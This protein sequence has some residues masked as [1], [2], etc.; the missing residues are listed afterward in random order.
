VD[1]ERV[2]TVEAAVSR[3]LA[4]T[5]DDELIHAETVLARLVEELE[6]AAPR[7]RS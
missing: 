7:R 4:R 5:P 2:G 3:T 1:R 6:R